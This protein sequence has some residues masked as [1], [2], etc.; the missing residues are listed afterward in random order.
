MAKTLI[1]NIKG[2]KGEQGERGPQG[3]QGP[4]GDKGDTGNT[5]P[6]GIQGPQG[7]QG[8]QGIQGDTGPQGETGPQGPK[9][10]TGYTPI[11]GTDYFTPE[12]INSLNIPTKTSQLINDSGFITN[13]SRSK[14]VVFGDSWSDLSVTNSVW[15]PLV[16]DMLNLDLHNYA[17]NSSTFIAKPTN[18]IGTQ[19]TTFANSSVDKTLV[20]YIVLMGGLNDYLH[21]IAYGDLDDGIVSALG[22]LK[23]LCPNAKILYISNCQYPGSNAQSKYWYNLHNYIGATLCVPTLNLDGLIGKALWDTDYSHLTQTGQKW[24]ARNIMCALTGGEIIPYQDYRVFENDNISLTI[25]TLRNKDQIVHAIKFTPKVAANS[26]SISF[27][28]EIGLSHAVGK[29]GVTFRGLVA[30]NV[31]L[32]ANTIAIQSA[33][34]LSSGTTYYVNIVLPIEF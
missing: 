25:T 34:N 12:D 20:K 7:E 28:E 29:H 32:A 26:Y 13:N 18:L 14:L 5:G 33:S 4:Q 8:I 30:G 31:A 23:E 6:Q 15:S 19:I 17:V 16:A 11:K 21:D 9:G 10:D 1:G 24:L 27:S 3:I 22:T 2:P